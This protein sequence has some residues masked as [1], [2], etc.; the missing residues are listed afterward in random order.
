MPGRNAGFTLGTT[1][2]PD[3]DQA[4]TYGFDSLG[5]LAGVTALEAQGTRILGAGYEY[6][7][8]AELVEHIRYSNSTDRVMTTTRAFDA[9]NRLASVASLNVNSMVLS[10]NAYAYN[11]VSQ[12]TAM[13]NQAGNRWEFGYDLRGQV[14]KGWQFTNQTEL[15]S[16][17]D[18]GYRFDPIGNRQSTTNSGLTTNYTAN[19]LNQYTAVGPASPTHDADGNLT[20]DGEWT[21]QW[22]GENRLVA[23]E[24]SG[25]RLTFT[26][27]YLG[28]RVEK[29][30]SVWDPE[31]PRKAAR[32]SRRRCSSMMVGT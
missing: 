29:T 9:L 2:D 23:A 10:S 17:R 31:D 28:R 1:A 5:R 7:A 24:K 21:Y 18:F 16:G 32:Q 14:S 26:Y 3:A 6:L 4:I 8:N 27:D 19:W 12:R 11:A 15:L 25:M 13:T 30:V 22:D 20:A